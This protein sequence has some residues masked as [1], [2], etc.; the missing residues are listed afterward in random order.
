M[1]TC[2]RC[3]NIYKGKAEWCPDCMITL[4]KVDIIKPKKP[5]MH[6]SLDEIVGYFTTLG[7]IVLMLFG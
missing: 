6:S 2:Y 3:G 4:A 1:K 7:S 5:K